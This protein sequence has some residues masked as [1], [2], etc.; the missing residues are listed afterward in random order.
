MNIEREEMEAELIIVGVI[1][2]CLLVGSFLPDKYW[3][4]IHKKGWM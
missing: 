1:F 2:V 4:M 3:I